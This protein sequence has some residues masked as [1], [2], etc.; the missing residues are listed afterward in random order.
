MDIFYE[1][2]NFIAGCAL[3][4]KKEIVILVWIDEAIIRA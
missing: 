1:H 4:D 3:S 2:N